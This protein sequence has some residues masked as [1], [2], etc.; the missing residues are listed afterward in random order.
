MIPGNRRIIKLF[1]SIPKFDTYSQ[2]SNSLEKVFHENSFKHLIKNLKEERKPKIYSYFNVDEQKMILID[3][4]FSNI[5]KILKKMIQK[6]IYYTTEKLL[7]KII[8]RKQRIKK[9]I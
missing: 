9:K 5:E 3:L 4:I 6:I 8:Q 7:K 1:E 2:C